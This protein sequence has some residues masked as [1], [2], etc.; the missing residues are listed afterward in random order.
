MG[1]SRRGVAA[2]FLN[3]PK[4]AK[5]QKSVKNDA[6]LKRPFAELRKVLWTTDPSF[7]SHWDIVYENKKNFDR[8]NVFQPTARLFLKQGVS[9][10]LRNSRILCCS[11][12]VIISNSC[13]WKAH[14]P[15]PL[16]QQFSISGTWNRRRTLRG[17]GG[18]KCTKRKTMGIRVKGHGLSNRAG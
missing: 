6:G 5:T 15:I 7:E 16:S 13:G 9:T 14:V 17:G 12:L 1:I 3:S 8:R 10:C 18:V 2:H 11:L 4:S